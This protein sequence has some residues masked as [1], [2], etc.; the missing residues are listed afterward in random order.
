MPHAPITI[1]LPIADRRISL[2]FY[3]DGLGLVPFGE[4]ADDGVP[5]P[6]QLHLND[7]VRIMLIPT[8]GF[9]WVIGEHEVAPRG[10][11]ECILSITVETDADVSEMIRGAVAAG[12]TVVTEPG[13]QPWGFVGTFADPDGSPLDGDLLVGGVDVNTAHRSTLVVPRGWGGGLTTI[14]MHE[15][16]GLDAYSPNGSHGRKPAL[17]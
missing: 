12:A 11:S 13:R 1:S 9:G 17:V 5:E 6:L 14:V 10:T 4:P 7:G 15:L 16:V 3:R 8:G 2:A